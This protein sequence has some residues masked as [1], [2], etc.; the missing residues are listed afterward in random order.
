MKR[1]ENLEV[2]TEDFRGF[3]PAASGPW[4]LRRAVK[5]LLFGTSDNAHYLHEHGLKNQAVLRQVCTLFFDHPLLNRY[6]FNMK[7]TGLWPIFWHFGLIF[8]FARVIK[9]IKIE[10]SFS[11]RLV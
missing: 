10:S 4:S 7:N 8:R 6:L 11:L 3:F 5:S 2:L 1:R 9:K